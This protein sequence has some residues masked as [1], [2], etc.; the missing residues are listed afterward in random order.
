MFSIFI[1]IKYTIR[2]RITTEDF[3]GRVT[4]I[5]ANNFVTKC[6]LTIYGIATQFFLHPY[7]FFNPHAMLTNAYTK[8]FALTNNAFLSYVIAFETYYTT[9]WLP[10]VTKIL[11]I[12]FKTQ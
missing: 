7:I 12:F 3:S 5:M 10:M 4:L 8:E 6:R 1:I 11:T 2:S 9:R